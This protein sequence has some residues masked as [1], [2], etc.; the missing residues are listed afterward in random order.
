MPISCPI[1][2]EK[3]FTENFVLWPELIDAWQLSKTEAQYI[4]RQ[5]GFHCDNCKNNLRAMGLSAAILRE[6]SFNG[7][8]KQFSDYH[9]DLAILEINRA[10]NLTSFLQKSPK[11]KLIEYPEF[12]MLDLDIQSESFDLIIHSDTLEHVENPERALAECLRILRMGGKCIFTVPIIVDRM[13]RSR[14]GL[15]SSYH[16]PSDMPT[17][18]MKVW[19]EFGVDVWKLALMAGFSSCEIY[20]YEYPA[21]LILI[22][23][24]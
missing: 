19:T 11:H 24:K 6:Y 22:A 10:C 7:L 14:V 4:D 23:R 13:S 20:A 21:A 2:G 1:C 12:D 17:N 16:G 5:Q 9:A 3:K 18:D 8:I 15:E